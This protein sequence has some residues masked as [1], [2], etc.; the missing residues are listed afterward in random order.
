MVIQ[1]WWG[2]VDH[3]KD[4]CDRFAAAGYVALAPDLSHGQKVQPGEPDEAGKAMMAMKMDQAK[5]HRPERRGGRGAAARRGD[6]VGVIGFCMGGGT[7]A[8][9]GDAASR[10][11]GGASCPCYGIVP[12]PD[13]QPDYAAMSAAVLG[14]YAGEGQY[15][16]PEAG[17]R[18]RR[19]TAGIGKS[20]EIIDLSRM[21]TTRSSTTRGPRSTTPDASHALW[22][23]TLAFFSEHLGVTPPTR[24]Q[25]AGPLLA[26]GVDAAL[27][28]R[29]PGAAA[30]AP[31]G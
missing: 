14:H 25:H 10:R 28:V 19:A 31:R 11:G 15:F 23:R 30:H 6:K 9:A 1:E 13:V 7:G 2:L 29:A 24:A 4:V 27:G 18:T 22:D 20:I 12:W 16:T 17:E 26:A 5:A 21:P 3:I 8:R